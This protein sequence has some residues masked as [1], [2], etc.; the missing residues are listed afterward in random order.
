MRVYGTPKCFL[1]LILKIILSWK[2]NNT[3]LRDNI[4]LKKNDA[5][6]KKIILS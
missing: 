1:I 2:K 4:K 5:K 3:N 6:L